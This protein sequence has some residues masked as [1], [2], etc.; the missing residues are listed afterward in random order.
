MFEKGS[1]LV[2]KT[3]FLRVWLLLKVHSF[4]TIKFGDDGVFRYVHLTNPRPF[5]SFRLR[6]VR[7]FQVHLVQGPTWTPQDIVLGE[8]HACKK[9]KSSKKRCEDDVVDV[10]IDICSLET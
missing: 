4:G 2:P 5:P 9:L 6:L 1:P 3:S 7:K 10:F 8:E